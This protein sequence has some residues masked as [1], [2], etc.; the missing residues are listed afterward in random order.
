M[1]SRRALLLGTGGLALATPPGLGAYAIGVEPMLS[2][3]VTRYR[4][5]PPRWPEGVTLRIAAIADLHACEP[6]MS[7]ARVRDIALA[8]NALEPDV[9]VLL[10]D[11]NAG[12]GFVTGPV[13]PG[14][15]AEA[16]SVLRAPLGVYGILGNH[17]WW[18]GPLPNMPGGPEEVRQGLRQAGIRVLENEVVPLEKDGHRIWL[19]GLADQL[20]YRRPGIGPRGADDLAATLR[21]VDDEAPVV[22][23]AHEPDLFLR[24][25]DRVGLTLSG[26]THGGQV[27]VPGLGAPFSF[28]RVFL[29]G[30]FR[31]P[32][33]HMIVSAGL[34][35]SGFPARLGMPPELVAVEMGGAPAP[36]A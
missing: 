8:T 7:A 3:R 33:R 4:V 20:A 12:H 14:E 13:L 10:G 27:L 23:L 29:Y 30:H 36:S 19:A 5:T 6:F 22:L 35:E 31:T 28:T 21:G 9:T 2:P 34:G 15:W 11:Y 17:D 26:H 16:L 32:Q 1:L 24:V 25:P 18:H